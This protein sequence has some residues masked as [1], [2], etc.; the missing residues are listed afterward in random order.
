MRK[1]DYMGSEP[2]ASKLMFSPHV[3]GSED[4]LEGDFEFDTMPVRGLTVTSHA[5]GAENNAS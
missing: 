5:D 1:V 3:P 2:A 4:D